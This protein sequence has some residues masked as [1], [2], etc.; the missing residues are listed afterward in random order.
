MGR[1]LA[2][3]P[4]TGAL[5]IVSGRYQV[6]REIGRGGK[7]R[8]FLARDRLLRR[9]VAVKVFRARA[10]DP[11][12]VR[13]QEAEAKLVASLNHFALTT[14][15]DA[16]VDTSDP[17]RPRIYLVMEHV[18]GGDLRER[19]RSGAL[20]SVQAA[21]LG[22]DLAQ[23]LEYLHEAGFLHRDIKPAN[24]LLTTR[25]QDP[26]LRGKL[27]DFGISSLIG[28]AASAGM[29]SVTGTAAYLSP[30]QADGEDAG[31]ESDVY[32]LGLVLL[33]A[34]TG[35]IA[36]PGDVATSALARLDR[37]PE[38]PDC[39][40]EP[41]AGLLRRMTRRHRH[42][43]AGLAEVRAA[44]QDYVV[45]H[46]MEQRVPLGAPPTP[47]AARLA[48]VH[49]FDILDSPAEDAFDDVTELLAR[50]LRLPVALVAVVDEDR[51]WFK[52]HRGVPVPELPR[53][54]F[55]DFAAPAGSAGRTIEDLREVPAMR[56]HPFVA[57]E[58]FVRGA[59]AANLE[60]HDGQV[61][62]TV[63]ACDVV[64]RRF[65]A[66]EIATVEAC[67]RIVMREL[68]LRLASRRALFPR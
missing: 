57:G 8:V 28:A 22:F 47:E 34:L 54:V 6:G 56:D 31:P 15:Y 25:G 21:Y 37:D 17:E 55:R 12:E 10:A 24:V 46:L 3:Q 30:E 14:L 59:I 35:R 26:R 33:E 36:F 51:V 19:L 39:V 20:S 43:R 1:D 40:P 5:E 53:S 2:A 11:E 63:L 23:G 44:L 45:D 4:A 7:A 68:E 65:D 18:A 58:P 32:S 29:D 41:L 27:A 16:G 62:G 48:A 42:E 64:P 61:I 67:A 9:E 50:S 60:T 38:V 49:R 13:V 52:S 66:E